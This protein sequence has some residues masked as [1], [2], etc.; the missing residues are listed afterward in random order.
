MSTTGTF[1]LNG[2]GWA[3][4]SAFDN[5]RDAVTDMWAT[6]VGSDGVMEEIA[7]DT[8]G[9]GVP[10]TWL[11]DAD[12]DRIVDA[13]TVDTNGDT[14]PDT[15]VPNSRVDQAVGLQGTVPPGHLPAATPVY[16]P[17]APYWSGQAQSAGLGPDPFE[18][19]DNASRAVNGL[20]PVD[21]PY[22]SF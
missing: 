19:M 7:L 16:G 10:D 15:V 12:E 9:E 13:V 21:D 6:D 3:D 22:D 8:T 5:D 18:V 11:I 20:D 17:D 4:Q 14:L 1:D 2:D